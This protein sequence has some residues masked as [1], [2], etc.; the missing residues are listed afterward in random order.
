[1]EFK[2][3]YYICHRR[4]NEPILWNPSEER[5]DLSLH[6]VYFG[7]VFMA[8]ERALKVQ[9]LSIYLTWDLCR[10]P[11]YGDHVVAVVLNDEWSRVPRYF[12]QVLAVFKCYGTRLPLGG[13]PLTQPSYLNLLWSAQYLRTQIYRLPSLATYFA[14]RSLH[15]ILGG[16]PVQP[17]LFDVPLGY[18]NQAP[19]PVKPIGDRTYDVYFSGSV[20]NRAYRRWAPQRWLQTP[21][22]YSRRRMISEMTALQERRPDFNIKLDVKARY[23]PRVETAAGD[24]PG[25]APDARSYS[26][27][28]MDTKICLVPRG[29]T[30]ETCRFFEGLRYGCVVISEALPST[31]YCEGAPVIQVSDWEELEHVVETLLSDE[32]LLQQK[33]AEALEWWDK[34]CSEQAV[35]AFMASQ[36]NTLKDA[37]RDLKIVVN[38]RPPPRKK[39]ALPDRED[40]YS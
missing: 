32:R 13:N 29:T 30:L 35:G 34:V 12:D 17:A 16:P 4:Y 28:L 6:T 9:G 23:A 19:L 10:L 7:K 25:A 5:P 22:S 27:E 20:N 3:S 2:N 31:W 36:L 14:K 37:A 21:K 1:M 8:V 33:H 11:D 26:E 15:G 38:G 39:V 18:L 40:V 24:F